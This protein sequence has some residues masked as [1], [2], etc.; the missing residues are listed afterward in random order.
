MPLTPT[1]PRPRSDD[2]ETRRARRGENPSSGTQVPA[3]FRSQTE[4]GGTMMTPRSAS[5]RRH[6]G[7][8]IGGGRACPQR[9][10]GAGRWRVGR[11]P[12]AGRA[13]GGG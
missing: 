7:S 4:G 12:E 1:S 3:R 10:R 13:G 6:W 8:L 11:V 9:R 2:E 5:R